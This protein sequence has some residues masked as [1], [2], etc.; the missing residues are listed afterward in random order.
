MT[1]SLTRDEILAA[2]VAL[3]RGQYGGALATMHA[4]DG[5]PYVT[6][7]LFH[8]RDDGTVLFGSGASPQHSRNMEATPEVSFLIDNR[9]V[10]RA[11]WTAF[12][13]VVIEGHAEKVARDDSRYATFLRELAQKNRLAAHF[14][15]D[16]NLFQIL[17]RRLVL[18][19]GIDAGRLVVDF[20][21]GWPVRT[22]AAQ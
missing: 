15:R 5:T 20:G 19:K 22:G 21:S 14:T 8:L 12:D 18:M 2:A 1:E 16:G 7:V 4:E 17:P 10:I 3:G 13:R 6:F 11:D 9:E